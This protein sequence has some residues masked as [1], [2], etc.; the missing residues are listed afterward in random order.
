MVVDQPSVYNAIFSHLLMKLT[1][2]VIA[3]YCQMVKFPTLM[4]ISYV[5]ADR[6]V[7]MKC[8]LNYLRIV[9]SQK[10]AQD[11]MEIVGIQDIPLEQLDCMEDTFKP[12]LVE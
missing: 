12:Q 7:A 11:V 6:T 2:I 3:V 10:W 4:G 9:E 5:R 1:Q 8:N